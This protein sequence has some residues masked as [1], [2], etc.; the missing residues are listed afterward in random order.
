MDHQIAISMPLLINHNDFIYM[1]CCPFLWFFSEIIQTFYLFSAFFLDWSHK[2][3]IQY[4]RHVW[5]VAAAAVCWHFAVIAVG[6]PSIPDSLHKPL[7]GIRCPAN[8][9]TG[10]VY[11]SDLFICSMLTCTF[12]SRFACMAFSSSHKSAHCPLYN[13]VP[14]NVR[15]ISLAGRSSVCASCEHQTPA[16][17]YW[18]Q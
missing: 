1:G 14:N 9:N 11:R 3:T 18:W 16:L 2:F 7:H 13:C 10:K 6:G 12:D 8:I 5:Y 15:W 17:F 4:Q